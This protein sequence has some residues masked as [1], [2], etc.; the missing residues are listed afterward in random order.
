MFS[1]P[2]GIRSE[3]DV[4]VEYLQGPFKEEHDLNDKEQVKRLLEC[5]KIT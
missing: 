5:I 2:K 4:V 3:T 1:T